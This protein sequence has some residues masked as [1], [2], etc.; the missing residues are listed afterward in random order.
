MAARPYVNQIIFVFF[1]PAVVGAAMFMRSSKPDTSI[2]TRAT[3]GCTNSS[4]TS[5]L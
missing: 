4:P 5:S 1:W 3:F 2:S